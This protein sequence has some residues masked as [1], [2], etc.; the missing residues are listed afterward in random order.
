MSVIRKSIDPT[1]SS[2]TTPL[3]SEIQTFDPNNLG[4]LD[5]WYSPYNGGVFYTIASNIP[6]GNYAPAF[7][8]AS[9]THD[10]F[11]IK[12]TTNAPLSNFV[13]NFTDATN[14]SQVKVYWVALGD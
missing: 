14:I 6:R 5:P 9:G 3:L 12:V 8:A 11:L 10:Q 2:P 4:A 13:V 1:T 7:T